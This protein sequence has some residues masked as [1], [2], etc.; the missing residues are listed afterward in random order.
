MTDIE[1]IILVLFLITAF[2]FIGYSEGA[3][4]LRHAIQQQ[5]IEHNAA[6]HNPT[7]GEFEWLKK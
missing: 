6:Q 4:S 7:T 3:K 5:A 2:T 1:E